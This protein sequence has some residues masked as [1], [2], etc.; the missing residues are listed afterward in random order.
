MPSFYVNQKTTITVN[1]V[2]SWPNYVMI[3][4]HRLTMILNF[5]C[6]LSSVQQVLAKLAIVSAS[7]AQSLR[8]YD[9]D[10]THLSCM[11][12]VFHQIIHT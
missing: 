4:S 1:S 9:F 5:P 2:K 8:V 12:G 7:G 10:E 6:T 11:T 3:M